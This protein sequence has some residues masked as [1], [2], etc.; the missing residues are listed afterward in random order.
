MDSALRSD[1]QQ[2]TALVARGG[3]VPHSR[4]LI[5]K[6]AKDKQAAYDEAELS[7]MLGN[8]LKSLARPRKERTS[9]TI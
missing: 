9:C 2:G 5:A 7:S 8:F 4:F 1:S 6:Q 3:S